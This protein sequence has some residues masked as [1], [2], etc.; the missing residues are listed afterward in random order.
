MAQVHEF[1]R[2]Y[3]NLTKELEL[4]NKCY[5]NLVTIIYHLTKNA[6]CIILIAR[7]I[8]CILYQQPPLLG[9]LFSLLLLL[10]HRRQLGLDFGEAVG[11]ASHR[12][13][14]RERLVPLPRRPRDARGGEGR[15]ALEEGGRLLR[16]LAPPRG[17]LA[18]VRRLPHHRPLREQ[19]GL[20][21]REALS[22]DVRLR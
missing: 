4:H 15:E 2:I 17:P 6:F 9:S 13:E 14:Q 18:V 7:N 22:D 3:W 12:G 10:L 19:Q 20:N 21:A 1:R 8:N 11:V 5:I 16:V